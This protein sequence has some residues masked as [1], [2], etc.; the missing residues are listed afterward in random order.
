MLHC[1]SNLYKHKA[2][3]QRCRDGSVVYRPP[4]P[5]KE[6][7]RYLQGRSCALSQPQSH[8]S[9]WHL[10]AGQPQAAQDASAEAGEALPDHIQTAFDEALWDGPHAERLQAASLIVGL[11]PD[12]VT[13]FSSALSEAEASRGSRL[14]DMGA[15]KQYNL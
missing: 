9:P 12:Q 7:M 1:P 3:G 8:Q 14:T 5:T 10:E 4:K 6:Q 13:Y 2:D 11:H 15:A